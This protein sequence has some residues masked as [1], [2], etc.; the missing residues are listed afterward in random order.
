MKQEKE[1]IALLDIVR[2]I[3]VLGILVMNIRLFSE[4]SARL[5]QSACLQ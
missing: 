4:P 2:G 1:R 3:A 5:F